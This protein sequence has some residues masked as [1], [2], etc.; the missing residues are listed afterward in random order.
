MERFDAILPGVEVDIIEAVAGLAAFIPD[1]ERTPILGRLAGLD[2]VY[3]AVPTTNGFLLSSLMASTL[4]T[5]L[6]SG[7][8]EP[9][10]HHM[11]PDRP[12]PS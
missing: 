3:V 8:E 7:T 1:P 9:W 11:R 2:D 5:Y 10:M 6:T 12:M 4:A